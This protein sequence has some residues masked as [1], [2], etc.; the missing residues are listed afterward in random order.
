MSFNN[1]RA[2]LGV[3]LLVCL[4]CVANYYLNLGIFVR[5]S[6]Q[7]VIVGFIVLLLVQHYVGP[8]LTEVREY[9]D[10]KRGE[11]PPSF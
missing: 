5:F 4:L 8:T 1:K 2:V 11:A 3:G 7:A 10:K 6:K 9:R